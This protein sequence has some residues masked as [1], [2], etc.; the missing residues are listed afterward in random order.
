MDIAG[1]CERS[2]VAGEA[3]KLLKSRGIT[4][5]VAESC[6]G[7]LIAKLLTDTPGSSGYFIAGVVAYANSA[8]SHFLGV[9]ADLIER[10]GAVSSEVAA[11]MAQ[12]LRRAAG[13]DLALSTTGIA[14]PDGGTEG[15]PVGTVFLA[16]AD[17]SGCET[18]ELH[19]SGSRENI[20]TATADH[21]LAWLVRHLS[22]IGLSSR[23][24]TQ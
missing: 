24:H 8:K 9:P 18:M 2:K 21:A 16:L 6:S 1:S 10:Y 15:K 7:G 17:T 4:I 11:A 12:G 23:S 19:L 14:G 5:A 20:R 22:L 13:S 3:A